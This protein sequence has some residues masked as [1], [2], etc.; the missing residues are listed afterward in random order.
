METTTDTDRVLRACHPP[1]STSCLLQ[2]ISAMHCSLFG[3]LPCGLGNVVSDHHLTTCRLVH[4]LRPFLSSAQKSTA[5]KNNIFGLSPSA[6]NFSFQRPRGRIVQDRRT[7]PRWYCAQDLFTLHTGRTT[8]GDP[9]TRK[10]VL[11]RGPG[12]TYLT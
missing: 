4:G 1:D 12:H 11:G 9:A 8:S 2:Y 3:W 5:V 6:N 7:Q 10:R